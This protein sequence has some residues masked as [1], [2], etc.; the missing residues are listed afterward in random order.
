MNRESLHKWIDEAP[1]PYLGYL[2]DLAQQHVD[3]LA[4]VLA[5]FVQPSAPKQVRVRK[6]RKARAAAATAPAPA[7]EAAPGSGATVGLAQAVR[8]MLDATPR[9]TYSLA[10]MARSVG[11]DRSDV[12]AVLRTYH[13]EGTAA[14]TGRGPGSLWTSADPARPS[15]PRPVTVPEAEPET[16]DEQ[17]SFGEAAP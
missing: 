4:E 5:G 16:E 1:E 11:A 3:A 8:R 17:Q 13:R 12:A 2:C 6:P 15:R 10:A 9:R 7:V 14:C